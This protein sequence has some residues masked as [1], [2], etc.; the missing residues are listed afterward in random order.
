VTLPNGQ[1]VQ[2]KAGQ[3]VFVLPGGKG[4][5]T[6]LNIN[7]AKLVAGSQLVNGFPDEL[8][9]LGLIQQAIQQQQAQITSG[10][11]ADTGVSA[12]TYV[13]LPAAGNG[14]DGLDQGVYQTVVHPQVNRGP[15]GIS[16]PGT[17]GSPK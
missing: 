1:S 17:A 4:L 7:L 6:V 15:D 9:S 16:G 11:A 5:T 14:L 8:S 2:L 3:L 12:D 10:Q 13:Q